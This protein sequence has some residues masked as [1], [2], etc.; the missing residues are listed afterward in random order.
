[1][2]V[3]TRI[4][5]IVHTSKPVVQEFHEYLYVC[6]P[7]LPDSSQN[8]VSRVSGVC[9]SGRSVWC[10]C[11]RRGLQ[12]HACCK[13][14]DG[15]SCYI[16]VDEAFSVEARGTPGRRELVV[17]RRTYTHTHTLGGPLVTDAVLTSTLFCLNAVNTV[18]VM[19]QAALVLR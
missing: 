14:C 17:S 11:R 5:Y 16:L 4:L 12:A 13:Y 2:L 8:L 18:V 10:V 1:M 15:G 6:L 19:C 7:R 3:H 9:V